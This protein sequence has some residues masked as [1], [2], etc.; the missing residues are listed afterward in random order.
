MNDFPVLA[1]RRGFA[2]ARRIFLLPSLFLLGL[3]L[4]PALVPAVEAAAFAGGCLTA[5]CHG[6][7]GKS[8]HLH[9]PV[10]IGECL[11]CHQPSAGKHPQGGARMGLAAEGDDLC[12]LCHADPRGR[13]ENAH[14]A[15]AMGCTSCHDPH[16][17]SNA[18]MLAQPAS[19]LCLSC[20]DN[21]ADAFAAPHRPVKAGT[22]TLCHRPHSGYGEALLIAPG[23]DLCL[24]CHS[25]VTRD[26]QHLH[27][28]VGQGE[29]TACHGAH[30][31]KEKG[32]LPSRGAQFCAQ[33]HSGQQG[34]PVQHTPV[35][36]GDCTACHDVHG[37]A[38]AFSL[39]AAGNELCLYCH[40]DME[41][42]R[43]MDNLHPVLVQG[44][45]E[46][47][48][49]H[50]D[51]AAAML[52]AVGDDLCISCH[53]DIGRQVAEAKSHHSVVAD[54]GCAVCHDPHGTGHHKL[55]HEPGAQLCFDCH[56]PMAQTVND[57]A[58]GH[59]PVDIGECW[60][61]HNPHGAPYEPLLNIYYP[62]EFY[63][64]FHLGNYDLCFACHDHQAFIYE[65]T[66][67]LTGF[68]N[69]DAN[70]HY[71]HVN[72]PVKSRTCKSCHGIHGADQPKLIK[73]RIPGFGAW[74]IPIRFEQHDTGAT[75][76]VGCHKPKTYDRVKPVR[77]WP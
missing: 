29:C 10:A 38:H 3:V 47:H 33:C 68:R 8:R 22:C 71:L 45:V 24:R 31:G 62:E 23:G 49:P 17:G 66:A 75:C 13:H 65:R 77:Y 69:G 36:E 32:M 19:R 39:P 70:L 28:P 41:S 20:H 11:S 42:L 72:R 44:C 9:G 48:D 52:P 16:G 54:E 56:T 35:R 2:R 50:G 43:D 46:C 7:L 25:G 76:F 57:A 64:D 61:C 51:Q 63:T 58:F 37:S 34:A 4:L 6:D 5:E 14:S 67:D 21:P 60:I 73:S 12:L 27:T 30:G 40:A 53:G 74:E 18:G 26:K 59:G 55:L 15:L 1:V